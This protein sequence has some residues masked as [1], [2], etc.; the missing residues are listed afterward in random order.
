MECLTF[1]RQKLTTR[2]E[3]HSRKIK[4]VPE[5]ASPQSFDI[6]RNHHFTHIPRKKFDRNAF[7][8]KE[9][10]AARGEVA[11]SGARNRLQVRRAESP[12]AQLL[13]PG[14]DPN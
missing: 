14:R 4:A 11:A 10:K 7:K 2:L 5:T 1:D 6:R 3:C 12:R 13:K 8:I 9:K